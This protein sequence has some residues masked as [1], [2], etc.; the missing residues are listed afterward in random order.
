MMRSWGR[1]VAL[2]L[3]AGT[4]LA[5]CSTAGIRPSTGI[6]STMSAPQTLVVTARYQPAPT[7]TVI[8][9]PGFMAGR[10][11]ELAALARGECGSRPFCAVGVWTDDLAAPRRLKMSS[12]QVATRVAQFTTSTKTG[13]SR[14]LWNCRVVSGVG[15]CL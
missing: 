10:E 2:L 13:L 1:G 15:E 11:L 8:V 3:V 12:S 4:V 7:M 14:A 9:V 5:A 6:A